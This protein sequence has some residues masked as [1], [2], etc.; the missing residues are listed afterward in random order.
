MDSLL[1]FHILCPRR[2]SQ[3]IFCLI[4]FWQPDALLLTAGHIPASLI[5]ASCWGAFP[6]GS[7]LLQK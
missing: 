2:D 3:A 6:A 5:A 1:Q 4:V 7:S